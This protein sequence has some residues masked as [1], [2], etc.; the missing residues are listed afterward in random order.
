M[1]RFTTGLLFTPILALSLASLGRAADVA[2]GQTVYGAK[3]ASCHAKDGQGNPA[4]AKV[5][6]V[7][8]ALLSVVGESTQKKSDADLI[9]VT[10]DGINKMPA[11]KAKLS[12]AEIA[13]SVAYIRT[14]VPAKK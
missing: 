4:M 13:D 5:F 8:P 9:K 2:K 14:L 12:E 7:E 3:C 11:Y 10:A 6:K 1:K